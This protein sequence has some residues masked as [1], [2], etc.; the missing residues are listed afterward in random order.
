MT[1]RYQITATLILAFFYAV[2]LG[3]MLAQKKQGI[4]T[5]QIGKDKSDAK[6]LRIERVMKAATYAVIAAELLSIASG[7]SLFRYS[8]RAAGVVLGVAGDA[9]FLAAVLAMGNSWRAGVAAGEHRKFVSR[10]VFQISRNPA[11]LG[12]DLVYVGVLLMFFNRFLL[13]FTLFPIVML[14][15]QILQEEKYL[16]GEFGAEYRAYRKKVCRYFGRKSL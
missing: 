11:F 7:R 3:K 12:F 14:H 16:A 4:V 9:F 13:L 15:L 1:L 6:R 5:D 2:Y 10:G 8:A